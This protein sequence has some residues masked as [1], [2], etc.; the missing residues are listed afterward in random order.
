LDVPE[1]EQLEQGN[2]SGEISLWRVELAVAS[3]PGIEPYVLGVP[4]FGGSIRMVQTD[5][6]DVFKCFYTF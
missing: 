4:G 3:F 5:S 1:W 2:C 6:F